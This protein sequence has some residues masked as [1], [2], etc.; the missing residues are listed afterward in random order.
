MI[1]KV[2]KR[3]MCEGW[4]HVAIA[5]MRVSE[6]SQICNLVVDTEWMHSFAVRLPCAIELVSER[7]RKLKVGDGLEPGTTLGPL[8]TPPAV[9]KVAAH[10]SD[11]VAKGGKVGG[12]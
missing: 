10:V 9:E 6:V 4:A 3:M 7:V 1:H 8:I 2:V 11:A 5:P 12:G